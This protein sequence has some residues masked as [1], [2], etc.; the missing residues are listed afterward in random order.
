MKPNCKIE[1]WGVEYPTIILTYN[2]KTLNKIG[3][4]SY[5]FYDINSISPQLEENLVAVFKIKYKKLC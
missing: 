1:A 4:V 3:N 5:S 2:W